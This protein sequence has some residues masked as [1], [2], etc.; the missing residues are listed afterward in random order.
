MAEGLIRYGVAREKKVNVILRGI[1]RRLDVR[2]AISG[3]LPMAAINVRDVLL[4]MD[5]LARG[6]EGHEA[7][8]I[9]KIC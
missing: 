2:V 1:F 6:V 5:F 4:R 7:K 9:R 8:G 3:D